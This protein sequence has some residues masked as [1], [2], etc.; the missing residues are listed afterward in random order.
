MLELVPIKQKEAKA[1]VK[2]H[3]RHHKPPVGSIFQIAAAQDGDIIGVII[4]G[5]P[6][7]RM[8]DNGW[9][10]EVTRCCTNGTKN[11][12]SKLYSA[13]WRAARALGYKRLITYILDTE[14]GTSLKAANWKLVGKC[15][16]G[17]WNRSNRPRTDKHP[18]GQKLLF[19]AVA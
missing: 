13:A 1:F 2:E 16:G 9:T 5:R 4:V 7:S 8:L 12:C 19:E 15:S 17:T 6:V 10:A 11:A 3:H 18:T 14:K